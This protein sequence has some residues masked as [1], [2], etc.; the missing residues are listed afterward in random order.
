MAVAV[1][2]D[3]TPRARSIRKATFRVGKT[4]GARGIASFTA[5]ARRGNSWAPEVGD[6]VLIRAGYA[7]AVH[8][9]SPVAYW[10]LDET[11]GSDALDSSGHGHTGTVGAGVTRGQAAAVADGAAIDCNASTTGRVTVPAAAVTG[12]TGACSIE[13]WIKPDA[14]TLPNGHR[15]AFSSSAHNYISLTANGIGRVFASINVGGQQLLDS[16]VTA[17]AGQWTHVVVTWDG[18]RI[19]LYVNGVLRTTSAALT[20]SVTWGGSDPAIGGY[21]GDSGAGWQWDGKIDEVAVYGAALTPAAVASHYE[22]RTEESRVVFG[23]Q[24]DEYEEDYVV[25]GLQA[26]R[27][28]RVT[29]VSH[30]AIADRFFYAGSATSTA[31]GSV[32]NSIVAEKLGGEGINTDNVAV[33]PVLTKVNFPWIPVSQC[34]DELATLSN[35]HWWMAPSSVADTVCLYVQPRTGVDAPW[36]IDTSTSSPNCSR[37]RPGR[38]RESYRNAQ[39]VRGGTDLT[40]PRAEEWKGDGE[41]RVFVTEFPV[42]AVPTSVAVNSVAQTIGIGQVESGK[43]F[44]WNLGS[45]EIR[46][47]HGDTVLSDTDTLLLYYQGQYP[48][49][50]SSQDD[51]EIAARASAEGGSGRYESLDDDRAL[52]DAEAA[53]EKAR[54]LL[55]RYGTIPERVGVW[56]YRGGLDVGQ[57]LPILAPAHSLAGQYLVHS[58][59]ARWRG[60]SRLVYEAEVLSGDGVGGWI[61]F[62]RTL[63]ERQAAFVIRENEVV[64]LLRTAADEVIC[65]DAFEQTS[66]APETRCGFAQAG[67][68]EVA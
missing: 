53:S 61:Q 22:A 63:L 39:Y 33:G 29:C 23:G 4:L 47:E 58:V 32:V 28:Y 62:F 10:R 25:N 42:G 14:L 20:G 34:F 5:V 48:V 51:G 26:R 12:L 67:F 60:Q 24:V 36:Q 11:S 21:L 44:Y 66:A 17:P 3:G 31:L 13:C 41:T 68:G 7:A 46:Q 15:M 45:N 56:T 49:M 27:E 55:Q 9:D 37:L 19:R 30:E 50:T 52:D 8:D 43:N 65:S 6:P 64:L 59:Q 35:Y 18:A 40:D 16:G 38:H 2:I 54:A 57:L 1:H